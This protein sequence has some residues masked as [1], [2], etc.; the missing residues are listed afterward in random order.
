[1]L[2][3]SRPALA[4]S[5][6]P[7]ITENPLEPAI[8]KSPPLVPCCWPCAHGFGVRPGRPRRGRR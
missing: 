1:L 2:I 6:M 4:L 8:F 3:L 5:E 7:M